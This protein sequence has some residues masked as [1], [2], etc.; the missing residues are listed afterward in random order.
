MSL[1]PLPTA[2]PSTAKPTFDATWPSI[3]TVATRPGHTSHARWRSLPSRWR[4][5][6]SH[7][8]AAPA[9][10]SGMATRSM[11]STTGCS[12]T[13]IP[14][15]SR[16]VPPRPQYVWTAANSSIHVALALQAFLVMAPVSQPQGTA[17]I[18][19]LPHAPQGST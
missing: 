6:S 1:I 5:R 7:A 2:T 12:R 17:T 15:G 8:V 4:G 13:D 19:C 11:T 3:T 16:A 9:R 10:H 14:G 18:G